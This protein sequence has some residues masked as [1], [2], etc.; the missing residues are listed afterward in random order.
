MQQNRTLELFRSQGLAL[1]LQRDPLISRVDEA[2]ATHTRRFARGG[3]DIVHADPKPDQIFRADLDLQR[4]HVSAVSGN[5]G[6]ARHRQQSPPHSPVRDRA[7][8]HERPLVGRQS[9]DQHRACGGRKRGHRRR[10]DALR[11]LATD[12]R[13]PLGHQLASPINVAARQENDGD[14]GQSLDRGGS[15]AFDAGQAVHRSF[16][17]LGDENFDLFRAQARCFRLDGDLGWRELREHVI[18]GVT[19]REPA[20]AEECT[21]E[22]QYDSSETNGETDQCGLRAGRGLVRTVSHNRQ[23]HEARSSPLPKGGPVRLA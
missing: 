3:Q 10:P 9:D 14:D 16:D 2:G 1:G 23:H 12:D 15:H 7:Q 5:L 11:E 19:Q 21:A 18:F 17:G 6:D 22:R 4:S 13:E 20:V 8:I